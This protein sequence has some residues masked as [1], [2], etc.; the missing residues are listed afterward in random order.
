MAKKVKINDISVIF[1]AD[2]TLNEGK[3]MSG[4]QHFLHQMRGGHYSVVN[5]K[6]STT[7]VAGVPGAVDITISFRRLETDPKEVA[8]PAPAL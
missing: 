4:L 2:G 6:T 1:N 7:P 3:G 8:D 5:G